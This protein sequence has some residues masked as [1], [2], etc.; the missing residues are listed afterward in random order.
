[1]RQDVEGLEDETDAPAAQQ[2]ARV[3]VERREVGAVDEHA[4]G[5][6]QFQAGHEVQQRA[7]AR[8]RLA[9]DRHPV[10]RLDL[11]REVRQKGAC[12]EAFGES[13]EA[14]HAWIVGSEV[15]S[16]RL[17]S[18]AMPASIHTATHTPE[19]LAALPVTGED[20]RRAADRLRAHVE[21]TPCL[22][23]RTLSQITGAQVYLKFENLQFTS[24]FKERG[25]LNRLSR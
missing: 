7:L 20:V 6:G 22:H 11:E 13:F 25:A 15:D 9:D 1:M 5:V 2:R 8:A 19:S 10:A 23:S 12:A 14:Q 16:A 18:P 4:A 24:S 17:E 21:N 3:V